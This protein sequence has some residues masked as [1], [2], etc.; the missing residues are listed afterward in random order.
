VE[1]AAI[2]QLLQPFIELDEMRLLAISKY[3][4]LLLKWNARINLTA[5]RGPSEIVQRHFGESFFAANYLLAQKSVE[6]VIDLGSGAGFPG[7]PFA[8]LAPDVQ[9]T[10]IESQQKK[11]TFLKELVYSLG[12][13]SVKVFSNRAESYL[14][15][16]DLVILRA[17]EKFDQALP[18]A[19]RLTNVGG[20]IALMIGSAQ[21][22]LA[23]KLGVGIAWSDAVPI[24]NGHSR[25]LLLG[26][27]STKSGVIMPC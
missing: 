25:E 19:V 3:I 18:M 16:A 27:K 6:T 10:L 15:T 1:T 9:V 22:D 17:V 8:I 13:K 4:D 26:T 20:G 23:R 14:G 11:A 5:I 2:A 21:I 7:V 12:L 24:P